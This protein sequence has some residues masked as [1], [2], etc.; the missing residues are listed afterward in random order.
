MPIKPIE[1]ENTLAIRQGLED[2]RK[3]RRAMEHEAKQ[4]EGMD[5]FLEFAAGLAPAIGMAGGS[6]AAAMGG[7]PQMVGAGT[8][9]GEALSGSI[10]LARS[11][12]RRKREDAAIEGNERQRY[13]DYLLQNY[14]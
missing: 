14:R 5:T 6:V 13:T 4:T 12:S 3:K 7:G 11:A 2:A 8:K 9:A 10:D 1:T